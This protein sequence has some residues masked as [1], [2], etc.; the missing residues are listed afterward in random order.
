MCGAYLE[1]YWH[2][3]ACTGGTESTS[4]R[5]AAS[6]SACKSE[7]R[8]RLLSHLYFMAIL[9]SGQNDDFH[10]FM[11]VQYILWQKDDVQISKL[12]Y[13][14]TFKVYGKIAMAN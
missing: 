6:T 1:L 2:I 9:I 13:D 10:T 3:N 14:N 4:N 12:L 5:N 7:D 11:T 8:R